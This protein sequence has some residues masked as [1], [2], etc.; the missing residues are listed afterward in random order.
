MPPEEPTAGSP[1]D[2]LRH[3]QSDLELAGVKPPEGV[4]WEGL[5]FLTQQATEKAIKAVLLRAGI[6]F[7]K[8]HSI[9]TLLDLLPDRIELP[10]TMAD[11][12]ELTEYAVMTRYPGAHEPVTQEDHRR[13]LAIAR[14]IVQW[15]REIVE[16][17]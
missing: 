11:A 16:Q 1:A 7:P 5:C 9:G 4:L 17:E 6:P 15:A 8:T 14:S 10:G 2:W 13:A 3:A 12:S